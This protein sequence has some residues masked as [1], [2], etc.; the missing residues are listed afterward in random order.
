MKMMAPSTLWPG[1]CLHWCVMDI[2]IVVL[3]R[4]H[5]NAHTLLMQSIHPC[6]TSLFHVLRHRH[7]ILNNIAILLSLFV[8]LL[9]GALTHLVVCYLVEMFVVWIGHQ[10]NLK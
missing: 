6:S 2:V 7:R 8:C 10:C 4:C 9:L 5:S 3:E 1:P